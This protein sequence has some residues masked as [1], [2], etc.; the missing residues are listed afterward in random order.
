MAYRGK[1]GRLQ[2]PPSD[3]GLK[4]V[5]HNRI[6]LGWGPHITCFHGAQNPQWHSC[7]RPLCGPFNCKHKIQKDKLWEPSRITCFSV[8]MSHEMWSVLHLRYKHKTM[9]LS[10]CQKWTC[11]LNNQWNLLLATINNL[12]Q[13]LPVAVDPTSAI[14]TRILGS[15]FLTA[16]AWPYPLDVCCVSLHIV[17]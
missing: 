3:R 8:L 7:S 9:C 2:G 16:S 10:Q 12:K 17:P 5:E 13:A 14:F 15:L 6:G 11:G 4:N 1:L